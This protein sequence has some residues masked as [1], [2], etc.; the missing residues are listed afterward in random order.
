MANEYTTVTISIP[1]PRWFDATVWALWIMFVVVWAVSLV[2]F[3]TGG[4]DR[5]SE[6]ALEYAGGGYARFNIPYAPT[7]EDIYGAS[8][9]ATVARSVVC[10]APC[11]FALAFVS[12]IGRLLGSWRSYS[13]SG[14][15]LRTAALLATLLL[16]ALSYN[17]A[18]KFVIWGL[19]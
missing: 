10:L 13:R 16:T 2:P 19:G 14:I 17:L 4:L 6:T 3:Y 11:F 8:T 18:G 5:A 7:F 15:V 1:K 9:I 12:V